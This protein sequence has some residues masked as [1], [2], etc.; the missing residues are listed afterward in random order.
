MD[1]FIAMIAYFG[2]DWAP[3][4]WMSCM[5]QTL[6]ITQ[7]QAL[8]ALIGA[9]FGG[10]GT[11]NFMLPDLRGRVIVGQGQL[12]GGSFYQIGTYAGSE[13]TTQV[14]SHT[15]T[16]T[17]QN[18]SATIKVSS[19]AGA[20]PV[21]AARNV[22]IGAVTSGNLYNALAPDVTLNVG[23]GAVAGTVAVASTGNTSVSNLSPYLVMNACI[24]TE[25]LFPTRP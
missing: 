20:V 4:G 17:L 19:S 2:F 3:M 11:S 13:N 23:G 15:H 5:G 10:N 24:A 6:N 7:N 8:F 14:V 9:R 18:A 12:T 22:V 16:A 1:V 21:P 25:G